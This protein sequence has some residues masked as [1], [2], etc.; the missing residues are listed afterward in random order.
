MGIDNLMIWMQDGPGNWVEC[1]IGEAKEPKGL[2]TG[3][4]VADIDGDGRLELLM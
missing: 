4:A 3:A 2:G 1:E